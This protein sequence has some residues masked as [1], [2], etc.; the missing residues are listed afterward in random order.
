MLNSHQNQ[1][2]HPHGGEVEKSTGHP[3]QRGTTT[4]TQKPAITQETIQPR[5]HEIQHEHIHREI[6][7]HDVTHKIQPVRAVE[8]LPAKHY[9][10]GADGK[11]V[12]V[13]EESLKM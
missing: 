5:V 2:P 9:I 3:D 1:H 7:T 4:T 10:Q 11:L 13:S 6:H 8:V 12:E